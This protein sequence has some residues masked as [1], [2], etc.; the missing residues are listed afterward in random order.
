MSKPI[1]W[2]WLHHA[3]DAE[4]AARDAD[5]GPQRAAVAEE[6]ARELGAEHGE[7]RAAPGVALR[8]EGALPGPEPP[9]GG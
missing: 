4:A 7:G 8:P 1:I 6:L 2:P 5:E 9:Q 3:D